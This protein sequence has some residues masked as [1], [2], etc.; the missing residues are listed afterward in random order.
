MA[1]DTSPAARDSL[2]ALEARGDALEAFADCQRQATA[3]ITKHGTDALVE[4]LRA[5]RA[6]RRRIKLGTINTLVLLQ[7]ID[8]LEAEVAK[9]RLVRG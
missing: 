6:D 8:R 3:W 1:S 7:H 4:E 9:E 5:A 2:A